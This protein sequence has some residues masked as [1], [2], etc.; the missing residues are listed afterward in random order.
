MVVAQ[1]G[2]KGDIEKC[3]LMDPKFQLA[4]RITYEKPINVQ[5]DVYR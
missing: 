3:K 5:H 1:T 4:E 2:G